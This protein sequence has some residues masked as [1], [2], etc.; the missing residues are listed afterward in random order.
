MKKFIL[1]TLAIFFY[2]IY[3]LYLAQYDVAIFSEDLKAENPRGFL[4]YRGITNVRRGELNE[5]IASAQAAGLD[6]FSVTDLNV[7]DKPTSLAGLSQ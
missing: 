6:F 2:L 4:D 7:F 1:P 5:V 3:G